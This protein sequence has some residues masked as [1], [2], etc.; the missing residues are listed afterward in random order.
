MG[1]HKS[2]AIEQ[3]RS[4]S[5]VYFVATRACC[6]RDHIH[7]LFRDAINKLCVQVCHGYMT[8]HE[9]Y[10]VNDVIDDAITFAKKVEIC[11]TVTSLILHQIGKSPIAV[12]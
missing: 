3:L 7:L 8:L 9:D 1:H 12:H 4:Q 11:T 10:N 5:Y 2:K 6:Q